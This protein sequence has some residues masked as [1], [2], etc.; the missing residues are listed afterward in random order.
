MSDV[1]TSP[2]TPEAKKRGG[3]PKGK[4]RRPNPMAIDGTHMMGGRKPAPDLEVERAPVPDLVER[5]LEVD[6]AKPTRVRVN[7]GTEV[8]EYLSR[9]KGFECHVDWA[10]RVVL[11]K[12]SS[13]NRK[14]IPF[15]NVA[16]WEPWREPTEMEKLA[17]MPQV[18]V[19]GVHIAPL[20]NAPIMGPGAAPQKPA[21]PPGWLRVK[22]KDLGPSAIA[23]Y[24]RD[25]FIMIGDQKAIVE[26]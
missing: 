8:T 23:A 12:H 26:D 22:R 9:S 7:A 3:W 5:V 14:V 18:L 10:R 13:G 4:P 15:D 11:V 16:G 6:L 1:E 25:G 20:P 2:E 19:P 24:E 21:V 17:A